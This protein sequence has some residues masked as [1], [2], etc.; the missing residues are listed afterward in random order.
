M[1][2]KQHFVV[3]LYSQ[4]TVNAT[5]SEVEVFTLLLATHL[6]SPWSALTT[7]IIVKLEIFAVNETLSL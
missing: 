5:G 6:Y 3:E 4:C 2:P 7:L 1:E